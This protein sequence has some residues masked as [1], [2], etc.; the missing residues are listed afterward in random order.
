MGSE[1]NCT[2]LPQVLSFSTINSFWQGQ[3]SPYDSSCTCWSKC[4]KI[5][6]CCHW[7]SCANIGFS[8]DSAILTVHMAQGSPS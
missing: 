6:K 3:G 8:F 7:G 2:E 1:Q 5:L 4:S